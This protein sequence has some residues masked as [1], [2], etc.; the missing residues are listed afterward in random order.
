M[1]GVPHIFHVCNNVGASMKNMIAL[2]TLLIL[3]SCVSPI[4]QVVYEEPDPRAYS[5]EHQFDHRKDDVWDA[6]IDYA[7][8]AFFAIDSYERDSG[9]MTV[10]F[11]ATPE[12]YVDC[13]MWTANGQTLLYVDR[14]SFHFDLDGT[15]NIRVV[16]R[17]P[18]RTTLSVN[19]RYILTM[20]DPAYPL[21]RTVWSFDT[22]SVHRHTKIR[23]LSLGTLPYRTCRPTGVAET[24]VL[25]GVRELLESF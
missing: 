13:G 25:N 8:H 18:N 3:G 23:N 4:G 20:S 2:P 9:L 10:S 21:G 16:E 15:M 22:G 12:T 7:A 1:A 14:P 5:S 19:A 24:L 6:L 17:S 11:T